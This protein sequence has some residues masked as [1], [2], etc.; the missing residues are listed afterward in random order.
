MMTNFCY[1]WTNEFS[2]SLSD[3][4]NNNKK[5]I[6]FSITPENLMKWDRWWKMIKLIGENE[7]WMWNLI[8]KNETPISSV[9]SPEKKNE[10]ITWNGERERDH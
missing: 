5:K 4:G 3:F 1:D 2:L 7:K 8:E 9:F 6:F 10:M